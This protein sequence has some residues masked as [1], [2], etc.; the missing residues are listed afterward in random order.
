MSDPRRASMVGLWSGGLGTIDNPTVAW[1]LARHPNVLAFTPQEFQA[2]KKRPHIERMPRTK[3]SVLLK[4]TRAG[5]IVDLEWSEEKQR[6]QL[7][8]ERRKDD[9]S[10][11]DQA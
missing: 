10:A 7:R 6:W 8:I 4:A 3:L 9:C 11:G 1:L 5:A 2:G